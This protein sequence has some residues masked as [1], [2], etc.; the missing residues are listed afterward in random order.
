MYKKV[1]TLFALWYIIIMVHASFDCDGHLGSE[2]GIKIHIH[3][4][5]KILITF[6]FL[7]PSF[8]GINK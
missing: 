8:P 7:S 3:S 4:H 1:Q 5:T 2:L 6:F